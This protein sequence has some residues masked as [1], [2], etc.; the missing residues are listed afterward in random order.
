[1]LIP[2]TSRAKIKHC[3]ISPLHMAAERNRDN[4][5]EML[6]GA[7]FDVNFLLSE[8]W[9]KMYE[10]HRSTALYCAVCNSNLDAATMLLEAGANPNLDIFNPLLVAVRKSCMEMVKLLVNHGANV[11][12]IL[13]TH[14]T[15]FPAALIFC[16][17][18]LP[19]T[20]YLMDNG[21]DA[22][23]CFKCDYGSD[24]HPPIK[25]SSDGR[26]RLY[27]ISDES[28][29]SCVQVNLK[30]KMLSTPKY[31]LGSLCLYFSFECRLHLRQNLGYSIGLF[32]YI[33]LGSIK[34]VQNSVPCVD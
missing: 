23:S 11:N 3:G 25:S 2:R 4:V 21:C 26:G 27:Y 19:M 31:I 32:I 24:S 34:K 12:S 5:L 30:E 9:S 13:S 1:M 28:T 17:N 22:L 29:E 20:K 18:S 15:D 7:G 8:D 16:M 33:T 10:D 14:P 6:I